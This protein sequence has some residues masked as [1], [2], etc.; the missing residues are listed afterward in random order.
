MPAPSRV[1]VVVCGGG[2]HAPTMTGNTLTCDYGRKSTVL[3]LA[4]CSCPFIFLLTG[5]V[6]WLL[7]EVP[8]FATVCC[9]RAWL[10]LALFLSWSVRREQHH[11]YYHATLNKKNRE[12]LPEFVQ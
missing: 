10:A 1:Q 4:C 8:I 11:D 12:G 3:H 2:V 9:L 6:G 7:L 5:P